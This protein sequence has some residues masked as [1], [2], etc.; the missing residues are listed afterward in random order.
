MILE[1]LLQYPGSY[2]IPLRT[3]YTL[4]CA[5][6]AQPLP[7][8]LSRAPSPTGNPPLS[9]TSAHIGWTDPETASMTFT[10]QLMSHINSMPQQPSSLPP[11][12]IL[13]FVARVFHPSLSLVDFP[14]ALT[15]LDYLRD[16]DNRWRKEMKAA[17][18]RVHIR[19]ETADQDIESMSERYPG[20]ALWAKNLEG[21]CRKAELYYAKL[22]LG[23]RR[24]VSLVNI[25]SGTIADY[26]TD[27]DQ[28]AVPPALQQVELHGH[29]EHTLA[30]SVRQRREA[31]F[32]TAHPPDPETRAR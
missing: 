13:S 27:H 22:W 12:F 16:L 25:A 32:T 26:C 31:S 3:M 30:S 28:R 18:A 17:F 24:W 7:K 6:R 9:P 1:H 11:S 19:P 5:P 2:E 23:L 4:N 10:S 29:A 21:K 14:Q 20:I 15:A 8:D